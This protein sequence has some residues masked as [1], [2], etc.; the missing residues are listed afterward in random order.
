[1][2]IDARI[3]VRFGS[4]C[5]EGEV[6][7]VVG[8]SGH[9]PGCACCQSRSAAGLALAALF[10]ARATGAVPWFGR[11]VAAGADR[12][13]VMDALV[14]DSIAS[15]RFR[16]DPSGGAGEDGAGQDRPAPD[17]AYHPGMS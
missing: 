10:Q 4:S 7:L 11:V 2:K 14:T 12:E 9:A 8:Q 17:P 13:A 1:M 3:P 15:A 16:H 5:G 6:A